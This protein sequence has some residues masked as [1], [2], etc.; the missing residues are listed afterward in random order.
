[1]AIVT[2]VCDQFIVC[3]SGVSFARSGSS[4]STEEKAVRILTYQTMPQSD[5]TKDGRA[6]PYGSR[7]VPVC[8]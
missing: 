6:G 3:H 7:L 4:A 8:C 5:A 2:D 1:M